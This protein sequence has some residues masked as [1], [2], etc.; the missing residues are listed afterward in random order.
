MQHPLLDNTPT[1]SQKVLAEGRAIMMVFT[2]EA[3]AEYGLTGTR[4]VTALITKVGLLVLHTIALVRMKN[5]TAFT[6]RSEYNDMGEEEP[7]LTIIRVNVHDITSEAIK[8]RLLEHP[9]L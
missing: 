3:Q 8:I 7:Q 9:D 4:V 2:H 1:F 5:S 6:T